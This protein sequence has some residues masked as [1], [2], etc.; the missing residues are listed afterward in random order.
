MTD[1]PV[2]SAVEARVL[3]S[4]IEKKELT[5]DV[6]PLTLNGAHAAANQKTAR[7]P[8]MALELTEI[9]RALS[10]LEQKGLVRQAFA[11]RVE[12]YEHLMAQRFSLTTPQIAVIGLLLLRGAQTAHELLARSERMAR[13][14]SIEELRDNLDLMIGRRPPLIQLLERAPGQREERYVHLLSGPVEAASV[15]AAWQPAA[16]ADSD[17]E[18]RVKALE[19]EVA[20]LRAKI[21]ALGG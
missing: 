12:R 6:Y 17:L 20:A 3:G 1:L 18:A 2:L 11:S 7:E 14:A 4:L 9:R 16:L 19:E 13:F 15:A 21:E 10:T 5:P 8:V